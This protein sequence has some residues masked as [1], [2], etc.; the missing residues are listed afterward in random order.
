MTERWK[1]LVDESLA[2]RG[3]TR[4]DLARETGLAKSVVS[5]M[6]SPRQVSSDAVPIVC[7]TLGIPMPVVGLEDE[8]QAALAALSPEDKRTVLD[9]IRRLAK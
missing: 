3:W 5:A 8:L 4:A 6:L 2:A 9:L 1:D 7:S